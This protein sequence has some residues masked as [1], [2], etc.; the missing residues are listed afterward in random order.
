MTKLR[1]FLYS[2]G[3][4]QVELSKEFNLSPSRVSM[5]VNGVYPLP[6]RYHEKMAKFLGVSVDFLNQDF[7]KTKKLEA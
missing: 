3:I 4:K 5:H 1:K 7:K 6:E 2:R